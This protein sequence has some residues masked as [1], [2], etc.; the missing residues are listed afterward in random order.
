MKIFYQYSTWK[1][2][3]PTKG[4]FVTEI[5]ILKALSRFAQVYYSGTL[6]RP[7]APGYGLVP[8][9]GPI[10]ARVTGNY[11]LYYIRANKNVFLRVPR[12]KPR[13][14]MAA[15]YDLECYDKATAIATFSD[16]WTRGLRVS[17]PFF[18]IPPGERRPRPNAVTV[19][20]VLEDMF[21]P[22]QYSARSKEIR[23]SIG[24]QFIIGHFGRLVHSNYPYALE[25]LLPHLKKKLPHVH[26]L[27]ATTR[28]SMMDLPG[29]PLIHREIFSHW[30]VP[31]AIS[32]CDL[33]IMGNYGQDWDV[34]GSTKVIEA[35]ACGVPILLG[36]SAARAELLGEDY[37]YWLPPLGGNALETL[38]RD[39]CALRQMLEMAIYN[40]EE[41]FRV[42]TSLPG[43]AARYS[44]EN[45]AHRLQELFT[46]LVET[47]CAVA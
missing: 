42:A 4:D 29:S 19:N 7:D 39:M 12:G 26:I 2:L 31:Y 33:I 15:P 9:K 24:G 38:G 6:F 22:L 13:I 23:K 35:A 30:K 34:C 20:Q 3:A 18:W 43:K 25:C 47:P 40:P 27:L 17:R 41:R 46:H 32:A 44:M 36:Y 28:N 14:W 37:T 21:H 1:T 10:E 8:Y 5:G 45:S 16:A 11:D